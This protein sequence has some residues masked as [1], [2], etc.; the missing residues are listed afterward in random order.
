M[1]HMHVRSSVQPSSQPGRPTGSK[2]SS[3]P[4]LLQ[5]WGEKILDVAGAEASGHGN[6]DIKQS[7]REGLVH[8]TSELAGD[9]SVPDPTSFAAGNVQAAEAS[10]QSMQ[11]QE[12]T[13]SPEIDVACGMQHAP[14]ACGVQCALMKSTA[15]CCH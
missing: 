9:D 4:K 15:H 10:E 13:G 6:V 14:S 3:R 1:R 8:G 12:H 11:G 7:T 2:P 5:L